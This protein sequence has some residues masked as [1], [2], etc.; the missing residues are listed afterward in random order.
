[1]G[2]SWVLSLI[3][4]GLGDRQGV[5]T[6]VQH[7]PQDSVDEAGAAGAPRPLHTVAWGRSVPSHK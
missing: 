4:A 7:R 5:F 6:H 2:L 1:M 3:G